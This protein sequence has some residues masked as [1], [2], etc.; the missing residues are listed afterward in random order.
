MNV[1]NLH[2]GEDSF[3]DGIEDGYLFFCGNRGVLVLLQDFHD[4]GALFQ[5]GLGVGVQI[6]TELGEALELAVLG[7]DQL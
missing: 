2:S 4:T 6:G 5:T 1:G 7:V 3:R